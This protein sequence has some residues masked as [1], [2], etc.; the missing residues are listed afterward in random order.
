MATFAYRAID[1]E[2]QMQRGNLDAVNA[3]DLELRL[4]RM[5]LDLIRFD[6]FPAKSSSR[7]ASIW[8]S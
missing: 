8:I 5:G 4:K 6:P 7:S 1:E 2:G 3:V